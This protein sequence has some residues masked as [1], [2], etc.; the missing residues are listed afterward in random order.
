MSV[1][2]RDYQVYFETARLRAKTE[3]PEIK[4]RFER[5][6]DT[7]RRSAGFIKNLFPDARVRVFGSLLYPDSFGLRS[8]IDLAVEGI[9]WPDYL[10]V[11]SE[12]ERSEPEFKID[13][14]DSGIVS[15]QLRN[16]IAREGREL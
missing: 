12:L 5:A 13:L 15:E 6:W 14:V 11:W 2:T 7:A 4:A 16:V 9:P 1:L 10:R 3:T 8:D